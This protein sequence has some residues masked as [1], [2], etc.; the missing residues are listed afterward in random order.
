MMMMNL[1]TKSSSFS[2]AS[3]S[4]RFL[5]CL[6]GLGSSAISSVDGARATV[7][8]Q[9]RPVSVLNDECFDREVKGG[10]KQW[11]VVVCD[12]DRTGERPEFKGDCAKLVPAFER[13]AKEKTGEQGKLGYAEVDCGSSPGVC[14]R[15]KAAPG[16]V[17]HL[18]GG[19]A[20]GAW[21]KFR[22]R[23]GTLLYPWMN[24][25]VADHD[26]PEGALS[27]GAFELAMQTPWDPRV[28]ATNITL[29]SLFQVV[30]S[31]LQLAS[32]LFRVGGFALAML[33]LVAGLRLLSSPLSLSSGP[34][35]AAVSGGSTKEQDE[36]D[37]DLVGDKI[38]P[39][40]AVI[41]SEVEGKRTLAK[42]RERGQGVLV[43]PPVD[44]SSEDR[45]EVREQPPPEPAMSL[46]RRA[47]QESQDEVWEI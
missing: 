39:T 29:V 7:A 4:V 43:L 9:D 12:V 15:L 24:R 13:Y 3:C 21:T 31:F 30:V 11:L 10:P 44:P 18:V 2:T 17:V 37:A 23:E 1:Q 27:K 34:S 36:G 47:A 32:V 19:K 46:R 38:S 14:H 35:P 33:A 45:Q 22:Q 28:V 8:L 41:R 5:L 20:V 16:S 26:A 25:Q 42:L 40:K 6:L